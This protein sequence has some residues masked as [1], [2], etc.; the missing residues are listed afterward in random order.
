MTASIEV[1]GIQTSG[2]CSEDVIFS[3]GE[4]LGASSEFIRSH[5]FVKSDANN[6]VNGE[7]TLDHE[8]NLDTNQDF[9]WFMSKVFDMHITT[10]SITI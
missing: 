7:Y 8:D 3:V 2:D 4:R 5:Q 6:N 9:Y 1:E 10:M